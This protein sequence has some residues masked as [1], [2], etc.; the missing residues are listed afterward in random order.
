MAHDWNL[1]L[2]NVVGNVVVFLPFG[3]FLPQLFPKCKNVL[4]TILLSLEFSFVIEVIQLISRVGSFDVD[5]LLL[6]TIGGLCGYILY[7]AGSFLRRKKSAGK[8]KST[9]IK[10]RNAK[11]RK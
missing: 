9:V 10:C 6:N 3:M 8:E 2:I 1:F 4:L 7:G 5:D 11:N